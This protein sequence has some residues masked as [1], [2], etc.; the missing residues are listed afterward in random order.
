MNGQRA[1]LEKYSV[2]KKVY[3]WSLHAHQKMLNIT[4]CQ[5]NANQNHNEIQLHIHQDVLGHSVVS[6]SLWPQGLW[7]TRF[8]CSWEFSRRE[9]LSG[10]P[11]PPLGDLP[12][13]GIKPRSPALQVDSLPCQSPGTPIPIR[14]TII[15]N[16][17]V[18]VKCRAT[19]TLKKRKR[20]LE[21]VD[22]L[23]S[24]GIFSF[25]GSNPR[26]LLFS[27]IASR[28]FTTEPPG[29]PST[30]LGG[31]QCLILIKS[32]NKCLFSNHLIHVVAL[33]RISFIFF[34]HLNTIFLG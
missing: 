14:I 25:Q 22:M 21:W 15:K 23:S 19:G 6:Q 16:K 13:P 4:N 24:G 10:L 9:Y 29:K 18:L 34:C 27:C 2:T 32:I 20:I 28:F 17:K 5:R 31:Y 30:L 12:N 1:R 3:R 33:L 8:L 26:L 7:P 11:C